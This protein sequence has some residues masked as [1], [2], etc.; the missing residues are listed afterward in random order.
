MSTSLRVPLTDVPDR[1]PTRIEVD[2]HAVC[3][4]RA[5]GTVHAV[6]DICTHAEVSLSEGELDDGTVECWLHGS[7]FDLSTGEPTGPPAVL[8][9]TVH[10]AEVDGDVITVSLARP[11]PTDE[12]N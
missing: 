2:G 11:D 1:V 12:R 3:L 5:G 4:V 6:D 10:H 9:L 7:R 8:P